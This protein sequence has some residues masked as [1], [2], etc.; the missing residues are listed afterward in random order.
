VPKEWS[1][2]AGRKLIAEVNPGFP[3]V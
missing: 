1:A 3:S 2:A